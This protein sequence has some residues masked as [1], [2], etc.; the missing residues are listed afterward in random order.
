[1]GKVEKAGRQ[2]EKRYLECVNMKSSFFL[3]FPG[4]ANYLCKLTAVEHLGN[5][6]G[7][8]VREFVVES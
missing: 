4:L 1:M 7:E 5:K 2:V 6:K 3:H 8:S